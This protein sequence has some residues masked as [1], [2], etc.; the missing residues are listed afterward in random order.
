[1]FFPD[2]AGTE[3]LCGLDW[4]ELREGRGT[5]DGALPGRAE[6]GN[7]RP[8]LCGLCGNSGQDTVYETP[9]SV[10]LGPVKNSWWCYSCTRGLTAG[11]PRGVP[12]KC[13]MKQNNVK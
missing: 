9:A 1:M 5:G 13:E 10:H 7:E 8:S 4:R 12:D 6:P 2:G 11:H 3:D